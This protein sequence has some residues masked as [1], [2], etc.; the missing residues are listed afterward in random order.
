[1]T[2]EEAHKLAMEL[3]AE[4][5]AECAA[6]WMDDSQ[7]D[8]L[9]RHVEPR[10]LHAISC[11][12]SPPTRIQAAER[13]F[14]VEALSLILRNP[15]IMLAGLM[16][17]GG[18]AVGYSDTASCNCDVS[19]SREAALRL[20]ALRKHAQA[21]ECGDLAGQHQL[22]GNVFIS[23]AAGVSAKRDQHRKITCHLPRGHEGEHEGELGTW[24]WS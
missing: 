15:A 4:C 20:R 2:R 14:V 16:H 17:E 6:T 10:I 13:A 1:M 9:R 12:V 24:R 21:E 11:V 8:H 5:V 7:K 18:C 19:K 3:A 22:G 23:D